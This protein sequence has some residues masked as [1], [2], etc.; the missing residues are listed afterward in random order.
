MKEGFKKGF[1]DLMKGSSDE[2][3]LVLDQEQIDQIQNNKLVLVRKF[4]ML[5][6]LGSFFFQSKF[7]LHFL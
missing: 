5:Q 3:K 4:C 6:C 7:I 2:H 1:L